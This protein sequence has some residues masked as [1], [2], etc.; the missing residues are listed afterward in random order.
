MPDFGW[1]IVDTEMGPVHLAVSREGLIRSTLPGDPG[2]E[3]W[4]HLRSRLRRE[5]GT[6]TRDACL[7][8]PYADWVEAYFSGDFTIPIPPLAPRGTPFQLRVWDVTRRIPPGTVMSYGEVARRANSPRA[9]RATG[10]AMASN[11]IP[12]FVP[13]HRVVRGDGT[14]GGFGG[15][16][17][18]KVK[19][20][21][22]EGFSRDF[23]VR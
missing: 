2:D 16:L 7:T 23:P 8:R 19:L 4:E 1:A 6:L 15:G 21:Q 14:L 11:P 22:H 10:S 5:G 9:A 3:L 13:C 12:L 20:L 18:L 17:P